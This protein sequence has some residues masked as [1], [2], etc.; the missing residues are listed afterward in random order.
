M[1]RFPNLT[2]I[3]AV[4]KGQFSLYL[5]GVTTWVD[6]SGYPQFNSITIV[7]DPVVSKFPG[8]IFVLKDTTLEI[9]VSVANT[10]TCLLIHSIKYYSSSC[11]NILT[12][13]KHAYH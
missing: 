4:R 11:L 3:T 10:C 1:C 13:I 8:G 2:E 6:L 12:Y 5:D 7:P 9:K